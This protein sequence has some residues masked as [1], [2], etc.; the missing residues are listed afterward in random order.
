MG[1][2]PH[3][4]VFHQKVQKLSCVALSWVTQLPPNQFWALVWN[5]PTDLRSPGLFLE[6]EAESTSL[7]PMDSELVDP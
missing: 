6:L 5:M 4:P 2:E 7:Q 3:S 1:K